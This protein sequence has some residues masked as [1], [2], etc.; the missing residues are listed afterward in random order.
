MPAA[1][2]EATEMRGKWKCLYCNQISS[3]HWNLKMHIQRRHLGMGVPMYMSAGSATS[4][5]PIFH[6]T[7]LNLPKALDS[8]VLRQNYFPGNWIQGTPDALDNVYDYLTKL[9]QLKQKTNRID[10]LY[11]ELF[12][13]PFAY[14]PHPFQV[15]SFYHNFHYK[16]LLA[17]PAHPEVKN[18][19]PSIYDSS[20]DPLQ[21]NI[22]GFVG[23]VCP[24]C[25]SS[26][27]VATYGF[28]DIGI[29]YSN[30]HK[31]DP[32]LPEELKTLPP[33]LKG[34]SLQFLRAWLPYRMQ[35]EYVKWSGA[36][37]LLYSVKIEDVV[38][39][40]P[41][42]GLSLRKGTCESHWLLRAIKQ[43]KTPLAQIE[44]L[45]FLYLSEN[46]NVNMFEI[47]FPEIEE[48]SGTY[49]LHLIKKSTTE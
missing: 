22:I 6:E 11:L 40:L 19:I 33:T 16:S 12:P 21:D 17:T 3:R 49:A 47:R 25:I 5:S 1:K 13:S 39:D 48:L 38:D 30:E 44:L 27:I 8:A 36:S 2:S 34:I 9:Q 18:K 7:T 41:K 46:N 42:K 28:V 26:D 24:I 4:L 32:A 29:V 23:Y 10:K 35:H 15:P 14:A 37:L 20:Q 43:Q 31:C 45:H